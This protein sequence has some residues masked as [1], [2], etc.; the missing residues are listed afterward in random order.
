M[1]TVAPALQA[2]SLPLIFWESPQTSQTAADASL[3]ILLFKHYG[4]PATPCFTPGNS[5]IAELLGFRLDFL[6]ELNFLGFDP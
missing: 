6:F 3:S 4:L 1:S 5:P 2:D